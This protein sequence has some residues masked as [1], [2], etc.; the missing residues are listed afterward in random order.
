[1]DEEAISYVLGEGIVKGLVVGE[2]V[3]AVFW[4]LKRSCWFFGRWLG[5]VASCVEGEATG[6]MV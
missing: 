4:S 3:L 5:K 6:C 1:M 2:G